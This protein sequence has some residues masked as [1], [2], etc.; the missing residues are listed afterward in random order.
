MPEKEKIRQMFDSIAPE[1]DAFNHMA[2]LGIDRRWRRRALRWV[3][4]PQVLDVACG[5]GDFAILIAKERRCGVIGVDISE[6]MLAEMRRK[7]LA[8]HVEREVS[9]E[10]G[11]CSALRFKD[12]TFENVT[13][14]FGVRNFEN[15][16]ACLKEILRV[17]RSRGKFVMLELGVPG[18]KPARRL[19]KWYSTKVMPLLGGKLSGNRAAYEY[20]HASV[21]GFP[22]PKE[23]CAF[24]KKCGFVDVKH[25]AFFFGVCR[26]FVG[27][28]G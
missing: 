2:S 4:G 25:R 18:W 3:D 22:G 6:K 17:L 23:W 9:C 10:V 28:K 5:T 26:L 7:V 12:G 1:Y 24:M 20:L 27:T 15:R 13:V 11:D 8:E 21:Q 19:Y 16:E 14:A